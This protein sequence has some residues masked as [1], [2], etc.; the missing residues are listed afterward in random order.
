MGENSGFPCFFGLFPRK[1]LFFL[2]NDLK[3]AISVANEL[4]E[5]RGEGM[6]PNITQAVKAV[7]DHGEFGLNGSR[8]REVYDEIAATEGGFNEISLC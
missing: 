3:I 4:C 5:Q 7:A 8:I 6:N 2:A 1:R